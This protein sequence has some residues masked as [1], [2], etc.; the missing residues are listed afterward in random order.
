VPE[1][2][3]GWGDAEHRRALREAIARL[4]A[5]GQ[6]L[7]LIQGR[8]RLLEEEI[9]RRLSEATNRN[10]FVLSVVTTALLFFLY[11]AHVFRR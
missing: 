7:E 6:D 5:V 4:D 1:R 2:E 10:L 9:G 8:A 11:R 3:L